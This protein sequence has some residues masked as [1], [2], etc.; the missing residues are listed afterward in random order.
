MRVIIRTSIIKG[1]RRDRILLI[2]T[3]LLIYR[4]SYDQGY[5]NGQGDYGGGD[6]GDFGGGGDF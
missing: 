1:E 4:F 2:G 5:D 6:G 3:T